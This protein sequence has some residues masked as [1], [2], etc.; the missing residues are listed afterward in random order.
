MQPGRSRGG[1]TIQER[2]T[3]LERALFLE[4]IASILEE[5]KAFIDNYSE[6]KQAEK[7][8]HRQTRLIYL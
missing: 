3:T 4:S 6:D 1:E 2:A 8:S 7:L 5:K